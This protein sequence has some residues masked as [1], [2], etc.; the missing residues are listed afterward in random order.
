MNTI[1]R[2]GGSPNP[3]D[4]NRLESRLLDLRGDPGL[5]L[6]QDVSVGV[7]RHGDFAPEFVNRGNMLAAIREYCRR[8]GQPE[9]DSHE[10]VVRA[11]NC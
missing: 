8:S 11:A 7:Q 6:R 9:L 5:R 3:F 10:E 2:V 1:N 4:A